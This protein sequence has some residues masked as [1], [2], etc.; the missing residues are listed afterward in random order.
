MNLSESLFNSSGNLPLVFVEKIILLPSDIPA[1]RQKVEI[2]LSVQ[3][4]LRTRMIPHRLFVGFTTK[5][6][7]FLKMI[8][9]DLI[10]KNIIRTVNLG[11][12]IKKRYL[13]LNVKDADF[14]ETGRTSGGRRLIKKS[15]TIT[16]DFDLDDIE[17]LYIYATAYAIDPQSK[18]KSGVERKLAAMSIS[19]PA[20][21]SI[22]ENNQTSNTGLIYVLTESVRGYGKKGS[23]W[24]GPVHKVTFAGSK[25]PIVMAGGAHSD[26]PHPTLSVT[27]V[28]NQKV[29]DKRFLNVA[30][31][32]PFNNTDPASPSL[33]IRKE[34][35]TMRK[36]MSPPIAIS[37]AHYSRTS[38]DIL[39][40]LFSVDRARLVK[41]NVK[42][43]NFILNKEALDSCL[44]I[45]DMR[46]FR[47]RIA[48]STAPNKLTPGKINICGSNA[49]EASD[50]FIGSLKNGTVRS[51]DL[52]AGEDRVL[53]F[54]ITDSSATDADV[55]T[56]QY[57]IFIDVVDLSVDTIAALS[58]KLQIGLVNYSKFISNIELR[59]RQSKKDKKFDFK[60]YMQAN[61][62]TLKRLNKSWQ[63][64]IDDY[65]T[66]VR[67]IF[68]RTPF[69]QYSSLMWKK[70][71]LAMVNPD[72]GDMRSIREVAELISDFTMNLQRMYKGG[73]VSGSESAFKV[74][75]RARAQNDAKRKIRLEHV[76][77][78]KYK[79]TVT[80]S[81]GTD[82]LD[83]SIATNNVNNFTNMPFAGFK[84]RV[85]VELAKYN[86]PDSNS[87]AINK[88]GYLSP[89]RLYAKGTV[90]ETNTSTLPQAAGNGLLVSAT[91]PVGP[92]SLPTSPNRSEEIFEAEIDSLLNLSDVSTIPLRQPLINILK[93][94]TAPATDVNASRAYLSI[95]SRFNKDIEDASTAV[96]GS[97]QSNI[98]ISSTRSREALIRRSSLVAAIVNSSAINFRQRPQLTNPDVLAP[99]LAAHSLMTAPTSQNSFEVAINYNSA[100]EIQYFVGHSTTHDIVNINAKNWK[101][102]TK[103]QFEKLKN[104]GAQVLCRTVLV[105]NAVNV[106]NKYALPEYDGLFMLGDKPA[107]SISVNPGLAVDLIEKMAVN[108]SSENKSVSLNIESAPANVDTTLVCS[109]FMLQN[110]P[111][112]IGA[113]L[114]ARITAPTPSAGAS[115]SPRRVGGAPSMR[116]GGG[117]SKG[118]GSY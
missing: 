49:A 14:N 109:S 69:V 28:S 98:N 83:N 5:K 108:S 74:T 56:Y 100:A 63:Q 87:P 116:S 97:L 117:G 71:L 53:D 81:E 45:E 11:T 15:L 32:L 101:T 89:R 31:K 25:R 112:T 61:R 30:T 115:K 59:A 96:S 2:T 58:N 66:A 10:A 94:S 104:S 29:Q 36:I 114:P 4:L 102:L 80:I 24:S 52:G 39:K 13:E 107:T 37:D 82:Y 17:N 57:K 111:V 55:G 47:T 7:L 95:D 88:Y 51:V 93:R 54:V 72:N 90:I 23:V 92:V 118:G 67:F 76:F 64:L 21:E 85:N 105:N 113:P 84:K 60:A 44:Q 65:L 103:Q 19:Q 110:A 9:S 62:A 48:P 40:I 43:G 106:P 50:K 73:T 38:S 99:S 6:E 26:Q 18:T 20:I 78:K 27:R 16:E 35:L 46:V 68:G 86:A 8:K 91:T 70:N 77:A 1:G 75:S 79:K 41:Q 34:V 3:K 33:R 12:G 42:L 22:I